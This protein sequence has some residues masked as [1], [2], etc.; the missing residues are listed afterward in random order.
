MKLSD[1]R[2]QTLKVCGVNVFGI[3]VK[4]MADLFNRYPDLDKLL[5]GSNITLKSVLSTG[6][7]TVAAIIAA[8]CSELGND[9]AE[10]AALSLTIDEQ[11]QFIEAIVKLTFP[12]GVG[13][14]VER[15]NQIAAAVTGK[16]GKEQPTK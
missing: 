11:S 6:P 7:A 14:F 13:P 3:S 9:E 2:P 4:D 15:L 1:L 12:T 5:S 16:D 10:K 8:G